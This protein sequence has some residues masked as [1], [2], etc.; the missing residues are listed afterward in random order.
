[1]GIT[2]KWAAIQLYIWKVSGPNLGPQC[3]YSVGFHAFAQSFHT[4]LKSG[5]D[6]FLP[7]PLQFM[8]NQSYYHLMLHSLSYWHTTNKINK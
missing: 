2:V 4:Q 5:H 1:M 7:H 6:R 3:M 8:I